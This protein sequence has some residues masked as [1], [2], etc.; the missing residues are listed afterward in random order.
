MA[1]DCEPPNLNI[2]DPYLPPCKSPGCCT[3]CGTISVRL[4]DLADEHIVADGL[5]GTLI[6]PRASRK[7]C[8]KI[9]TRFETIALRESPLPG[10][11]M[12]N[13]KPCTLKLC[14]LKLCK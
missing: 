9:I 13:L 14:T 5:S 7:C 3:H 4:D 2:E 6:L 1:D 11:L 10:R 8:Q 12:F